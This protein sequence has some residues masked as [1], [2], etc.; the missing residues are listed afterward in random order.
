MRLTP[1]P[2]VASAGNVTEADGNGWF[3]VSTQRLWLADRFMVVFKCWLVMVV[4][5]TSGC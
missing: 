4:S 2:E 5:C 1:G 3:M